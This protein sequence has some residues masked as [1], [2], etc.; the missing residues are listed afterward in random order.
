MARRRKAGLASAKP[1]PYE[2]D[3]RLAGVRVTIKGERGQYTIHSRERN[4]ENNKQWFVLIG[5]PAGVKQWRHKRP[6]DVKL[7][8]GQGRGNNLHSEP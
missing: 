8:K 2:V 6:S 5:G 7:V 3:L 4:P 1:S